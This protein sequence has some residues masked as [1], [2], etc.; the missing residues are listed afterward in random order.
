M[1]FARD[2]SEILRFK[3]FISISSN[4]SDIKV[5]TSCSRT[6]FSKFSL[7]VSVSIL[8]LFKKFMKS[9]VEILL[10]FI[11]ATLFVFPELNTPPMPHNTK[12]TIIITKTILARKVFENFLILCSIVVF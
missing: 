12:G 3:S 4:F 10:L 1:F 6:L 11:L 7:T 8:E 9:C 2:F 5:D